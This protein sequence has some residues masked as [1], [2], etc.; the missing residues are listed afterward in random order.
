MSPA[1]RRKP[2]VTV[3][4]EKPEGWLTL[5]E[6]AVKLR[7][8]EEAVKAAAARCKF[9]ITL[10]RARGT[11][12]RIRIFPPEAADVLRRDDPV[13]SLPFVGPEMI[14]QAD[15]ARELGVDP[16]TLKKRMKKVGIAG[17]RCRV[18]GDPPGMYFPRDVVDL[19]TAGADEWVRAVDVVSDTHF[20]S[21]APCSWAKSRGLEVRH[22]EIG[23]GFTKT[24]RLITRSVGNGWRRSVGLEPL[25]AGDADDDEMLPADDVAEGS[26]LPPYLVA[27]WCRN[28]GYASERRGNKVYVTAA[29]ARAWQDRVIPG[30]AM[31]ASR[32]VGWLDRSRAQER[33][34]VAPN[35]LMSMVR[36]GKIGA[37]LV[38]GLLYVNPA[39]VEAVAAERGRRAPAGYVVIPND[40]AKVWF[41][42]RGIEPVAFNVEGRKGIKRRLHVTEAQL[43]M[44]ERRERAARSRP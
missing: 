2:K 18:V 16:T 3:L 27:R 29:G 14:S 39:D 6:L 25:Q 1:K 8:S 12:S 44:Y 15:L 42:R 24:E 7:E 5:E 30:V 10:W 20:T 13:L 32:P 19:I 23:F 26:G 17:Q 31:V 34:R 41:R 37:V 11:R 36:G 28:H 33:L 38:R 43:A 4:L 9:Q 35:T 22:R 21:C 40:T